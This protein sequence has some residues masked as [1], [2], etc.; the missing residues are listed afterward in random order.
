MGRHSCC[1][2]QKLRKG[3][4]SP[5]EDEKLLKYITRFGVGCWSSVP[6]HAGL[7]RCGKSCRLRWINYLRPDLKRGSFSQQ[8]EDLILTLHQVLGNRW[9]QIAAQLPG[10]TDN[11][12]KN[13]WNSCLRKKLMKLGIDPN[14]HKPITDHDYVKD[15][16]FEFLDKKSE[17]FSSSSSSLPMAGEL[18]QSFHISNGGLVL[19]SSSSSMD[20]NSLRN[21]LLS[22]SVCDPLFLIEFQSG[23]DP[24][25]YNTNLLTQFHQTSYETSLPNLANFDHRNNNNNN[26]AT[27][28]CD[29]SG[30]KMATNSFM[31]NEGRESSSTTNSSNM[32][33]SLSVGLQQVT[34]EGEMFQ[35]N[36]TNNVNSEEGS[37][38]GQWQHHMHAVQVTN[39]SDFSIYPMGSLP[40]EYTD[41]LN[42]T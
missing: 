33:T 6:K 40:G 16:R 10:R 12:I 39:A 34:F 42:Q 21:T 22:K 11:E 4:W 23:I 31:I 15:K 8:E 38:V 35:Y 36:G 17:F 3:L 5:E 25:G 1:V 37:C 7:Q 27:D 13:F 18:D 9:A 28:F 29:H 24:M 30:S 41:V 26:N 20:A 14:T 32:N 2:K 19:S